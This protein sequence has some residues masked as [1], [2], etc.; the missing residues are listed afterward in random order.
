MVELSVLAP[1]YLEVKWDA[2]GAWKW[3]NLMAFAGTHPFGFVD[4]HAADDAQDHPL[5][6]GR[7]QGVQAVTYGLERAHLDALL[8]FA[9]GLPG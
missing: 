4:D 7:N 6:P 3:R 8:S 9:A 5:L 2:I 1:A